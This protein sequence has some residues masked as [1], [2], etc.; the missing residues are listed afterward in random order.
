M[1]SNAAAAATSH[2]RASDQRTIAFSMEASFGR[3]AAMLGG[4]ERRRS[5]GDDRLAGFYSAAREQPTGR[6][7]R[8]LQLA[9]HERAR[10]G[11]GIGPARAADAQDRRGGYENAASG[12]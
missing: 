8:S 10:P 4:V 9:P 3:S 6:R 11:H 1:T 5:A 7:K 2:G 12:D